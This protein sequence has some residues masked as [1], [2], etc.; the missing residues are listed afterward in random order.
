MTDYK[1]NNTLFVYPTPHGAYYATSSSGRDKA[2]SLVRYLLG[3]DVTPVGDA[4]LV[5][6]IQQ[7]TGIEEAEALLYQM[8]SLNYLTGIESAMPAPVGALDELVADL[9][10]ALSSKGKAMLT[11][12]QGFYVA[13]TGFPHE[14][15]SELA[16]FAA[17]LNVAYDRRQS[18]LNRNLGFETAAMALIDSSGMS[19]IGFW[20]IHAGKTRFSLVLEGAPKFNQDAYTRLVW[21]LM[22]RYG[23]VGP[24]ETEEEAGND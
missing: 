24:D 2:R 13:A 14:T 16:A 3:L 1:L 21:T 15:A 6:N 19:E 9:I 5:Q 10:I 8:Q 7:Q 23:V 12:D 22:R 17:E 20:P 11:D 18:V 4:E